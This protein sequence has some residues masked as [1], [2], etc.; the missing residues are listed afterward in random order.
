MFS[1]GA[2]LFRRGGHLFMVVA[3]VFVGLAG[4]TGAVAF[5]L[6][7]RTVQAVAF[8]GGEGLAELAEQ[9]LLAEASDPMSAVADVPWYGRILAPAIGGL[10][11]GPLIYF[12]A[13]EA[14]GHG[15]PEVMKAVALRGG[16]IRVRIVAVKALASALSIGSGGSVGREGPIVQIG[17]A[18]GSG[19]GQVL[20]LNTTQIRT[21]VGCGAAAGISATFNAPIAGALFASEIIIGGF[22]VAE[23]TPIV[24]SAVVAVVVSRFFLGNTPAFEVPAYE[25]VSP[26]ELL[27]YMGVGIAAGLVAVAFIRTLSYSEDLFEKVPVPEYL[28]AGIGGALVGIIAIQL[29]NVYGVGYTTISW[30]LAGSLPLLTMGLLVLAKI[31]ATSIT[32]GSGGSGGIFAPSLFLGAMTGGFLGS[33]IHTYFPESTAS[34]GAYALVTMGAVVAATTHAPIS[35][36]IIIFEL[37]QTI[38]II[39]ALMSACVVS[40]LVSQLL[41]RESIYTSKLMRQGIDLY[42]QED[43]NVL[44]SLFVRDVLDPEPEVVSASASFKSILDLV[45]QSRH[46]QFFVVDDQDE[47]LGAISLSELRRLI[48][49]QDALQLVVVAG[50]LVDRRRPTVSEDDHLDLVMH[51]FSGREYDELAVVDANNRLVGSIIQKD[52]IEAHNREMLRRDPTGALTTGVDAVSKG[53]TVDLGDGYVLRELPVPPH[54]ADQTLRQ[55]ALREDA[56][57]HVLLVRGRTSSGGAKALRVPG[58]DHLL[59][60]GDRL[61]VAG[62]RESVE[63]FAGLR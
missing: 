44:K 49:E 22:A 19:I 35:A 50:D 28:R 31:L 24:I 33:L 3:A 41:H 46:S 30:A 7:I 20:K 37:T 45:V 11:V 43:P 16:V 13:R 56:D 48:Y 29:P 9:G 57:V 54:F 21:L 59:E 10:L 63:R 36:I 14:R 2:P 23:F 27:P 42:K 12:F 4:A 5:R 34:S 15:V 58:P 47:L 51:M 18:F 55:A 39:P 53:Q 60:H 25:I 8:D 6:L 38:D 1:P 62:S 40:T 52:V 17:S 32:I 26:F 61:V